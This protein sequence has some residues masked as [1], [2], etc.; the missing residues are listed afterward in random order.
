MHAD[1]RYRPSLASDLME[2][3][4]RIAIGLLRD[5]ALGRMDA[6]ET[7]KGVC[8]LVTCLTTFRTP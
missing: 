4:R 3:V 8:R 1:K 2:P 5:Q 7:W 6:I